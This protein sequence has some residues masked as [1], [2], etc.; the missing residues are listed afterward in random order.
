MAKRTTRLLLEGDRNIT[1][2]QLTDDGELGVDSWNENSY[3]AIV[4]D[5]GEMAKMRAFLARALDAHKKGS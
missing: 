2:W 4:F 5:R 1:R 3:V